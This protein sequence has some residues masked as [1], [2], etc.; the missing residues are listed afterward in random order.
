MITITQIIMLILIISF[1]SIFLYICFRVKEKF[2]EN[3]KQIVSLKTDKL[4]YMY[5]LLDS[6][7]DILKKNNIAHYIDCGTLLGCIREN[8]LLK[9]DTD[10]DVTIHLSE[11]EKLKRIDFTTIGLIKTR[12][13]EGSY[14]IISVKFPNEKLYCDIYGNPAFPQLETKSMVNTKGEKKLYNVPVQSDLYLTLL[15]GNWREPSGKHA[16]WPNFFYNELIISEYK[17]YWDKRY[18]ISFPN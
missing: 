18:K 15:Y 8:G 13:K 9:H 17:K 4:T 16:D 12:Q 7:T 2:K 14:Y 11:W 6:V 5:S 1:I 3:K 10:V